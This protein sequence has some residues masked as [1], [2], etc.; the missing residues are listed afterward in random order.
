MEHLNVRKT[1]VVVLEERNIYSDISRR[2]NGRIYLG[3]VGGVRT[4]K[5]T[6]IKRFMD[7]LVI[8]NIGDD[9][10]RRRTI[11]ELPQSAAGRTIMTTEP[12]FIPEEAVTVSLD[13]GAS[14]S[15]R[16]IDC[17][18]YIVPSALGYIE[19]EQPR[20]VKTPWYDEEIPF[21]MAAEIGTQKVISDHSSVGIVV[22]TDGSVT[23][24]PREE[25]EEA[26]QRV[27]GE[28]KDLGKPFV[29]LLNCSEPQSNDAKSLAKSL[30][31]RYG[32]SVIP[33]NCLD[34]GEGEIKRILASVLFEFP[35]REIAV[36]MPKWVGSLEK[37]HRIKSG[38]FGTIRSAAANAVKLRDIGDI[39]EEVGKCEFVGSAA[40]GSIDLGTGRAR[41]NVTLEKGLFC[42]VV[43][44]KTGMDVGD[45]ADI[46]KMAVELSKVKSEFDK[47]KAAYSEA[48]DTGYGIVMP[49]MEDL[50]L[51]EPQIIR[52]GSRYGIKLRATAPSI[53]M[54][55]TNITTEV[56]PIV[57]SE[58]QSEELVSYLLS[59]FDDDPVK[60]WQSNIF[61]KSLNELVNE[62]MHNKLYRMPAEARAKLN[63][64]IERIINDGCNGLI[65]VIL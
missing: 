26:E 28:L 30:S 65:C 29:V 11:D 4:G 57:G 63:E 47:I 58:E 9:S 5:S 36:D 31:E 40:P 24:I 15:V 48:L 49:S 51:E 34:L 56:T 52:Q 16:M 54:L 64:T 50:T 46:L 35:V 59:E 62:G 2:T 20:M 39:C 21:N 60:I 44:E 45:E 42:G 14:L 6:F 23:D 19:D 25:Y 38:V 32:V 61:G 55:K 13:G 41:I 43:S 37:E 10:L 18:G 8:P 3:V 12:K 53:H 1:E 17:V 7:T 33:V 27:I 22:T